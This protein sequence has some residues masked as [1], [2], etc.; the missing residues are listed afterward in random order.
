VGLGWQ[1]NPRFK[2]DALRSIP[3]R[4]MAPLGKVDGVHWIALQ[5]GPAL[6]QAR[7]NPPFS[8]ETLEAPEMLR[9]FLDTAALI[10]QLDLVITSDTAL[11]HLAGAIGTPVWI[12]LPH[13]PDWRWLF[14]GSDC[15]WYPS[16]RLFRQRQRNDWKFVFENIATELAALAKPA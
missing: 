15:P 5:Q 4:E 16:A 9:S 12:A 2:R 8:I 14:S 13:V 11:A 1:G 10:K 6:K 3:L 7:D